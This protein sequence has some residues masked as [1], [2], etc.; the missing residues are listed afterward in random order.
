[1]EKE[2]YFVFT[3]H[4]CFVDVIDTPHLDLARACPWGAGSY[5]EALVEEERDR[6]A[7]RHECGYYVPD[8]YE[9]KELDAQEIADR[10][11]IIYDIDDLREM[12]AKGHTLPRDLMIY[13][14]SE[15]LANGRR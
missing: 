12:I 7:D 9:D 15:E 6:R 14:D 8:G 10:D 3:R 5:E 1:M 4:G 2:L 11:L 13:L